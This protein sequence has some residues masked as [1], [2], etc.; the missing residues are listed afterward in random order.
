LT[1]PPCRGFQK[2]L[3]DIDEPLEH[4]LGRLL[5]EF[6]LLRAVRFAHQGK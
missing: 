4:L 6:E 1:G 3:R 5:G 2:D